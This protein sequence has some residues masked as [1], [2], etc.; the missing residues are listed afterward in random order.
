[1][2]SLKRF[3]QNKNTVTV[4]GV[5]LILGVL[6]LGYRYQ[7]NQAVTPVSGI[8]VAIKTIQPRTKITADMIKTIEVA[9]VVLSENVITNKKDV[10]GKYTAVN[11]V[12]PAGSMFYTNT[13]VEKEV[14]PDSAFLDLKK[15]EVPYNF[16]VTIDSTYGN[17][18][19]PD[20]YIDIYMKSYNEN[21][22]LM[23]GRLIENVKVIAVKDQQG[24]NVFENSDE[25][26]IPAFLIFALDNE[27]NILLRKASFLND[28]SVE[29][30]PVPHGA[31]VTAKEGETMVSS[32]N[33]KDFINAN[34]L[35]NDDL[36]VN[37]EPKTDE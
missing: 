7:I 1:M 27:L 34:T 32:Q 37:E 12:I 6:V 3:F 26:R 20:S 36:N 25:V 28:Y 23:V 24:K 8:P 11:S 19:V 18:I 4:I 30:F 35:P 10:I 31:V 2:D 14:L 17:S 22:E 33:L 9:P 21:G 5:L 15:D 16:P 13:V 29:L